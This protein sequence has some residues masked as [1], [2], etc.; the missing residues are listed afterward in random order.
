MNKNL[1]KI[2]L[3]NKMMNQHERN[4]INYIFDKQTITSN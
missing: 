3:Q 1:S 2:D 4:L